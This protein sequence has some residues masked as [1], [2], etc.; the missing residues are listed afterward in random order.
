MNMGL[1][2]TLVT[3][4]LFILLVIYF[5][6]T[7]NQLVR[8]KVQI[9]ESWSS[10]DV[11]LKKRNDLIPNLV[12]TVKGYASHEKDLFTNIAKYRNM[13]TNAVSP[14]DKVQAENGMKSAMMNLF[15]VA[16]NYPELKA[17]QNFVGL[18]NELSNMED[19]IE[20][21]RRYYNGTVRDNN[22][23]V[24]TFPSNLIANIFGFKTSPFFEITDNNE[25]TASKVS[26]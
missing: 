2:I 15:A 26:F 5:I 21:A 18:Q 9:S 6:S 20:M 14:E 24:A 12:E 10:I 11:F 8:Y 3:F 22:T 25:R 17:N 1:I 16:E 19:E 13:S 7:Y 23:K 4:T